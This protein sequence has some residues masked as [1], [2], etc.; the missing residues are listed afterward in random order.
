MG[1]VK[2]DLVR[3]QFRV[4]T[5]TGPEPADQNTAYVCRHCGNRRECLNVTRMSNHLDKC[6]K[7]Q[8]WLQRQK[9]QVVDAGAGTESEPVILIDSEKDDSQALI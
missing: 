7:Y 8:L 6:E 1:R 3:D 4:V 9:K 5:I 2:K